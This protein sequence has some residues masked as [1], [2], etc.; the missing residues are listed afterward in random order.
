MQDQYQSQTLR[1]SKGVLWTGRVLS[2]LPVLLMFGGGLYMQFHIADV[3]QGME[4]YG[5]PAS[6]ARPILTVEMICALIY[7]IPQTA[8][9]GAILLTGYL[10]GAVAT[11]V[12]ASE[13]WFIPVIVGVVVWLG[14]WLREPRLRALLPLRCLGKCALSAE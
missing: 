12:H 8:T 11:H 14:L 3:Q 7:A 10:G 1:V 4:K 9:L 2:A 13:P 5:Y 6:V